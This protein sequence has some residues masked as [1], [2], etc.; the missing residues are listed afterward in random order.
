[1]MGGCISH[2]TPNLFSEFYHHHPR[3]VTISQPF[4]EVKPVRINLKA[5]HNNDKLEEQLSQTA[6]T[7]QTE[8]RNDHCFCVLC[9][10][11]ELTYLATGS[12]SRGVCKDSTHVCVPLGL[13]VGREAGTVLL[14]GGYVLSLP[15]PHTRYEFLATQLAPGSSLFTHSPLALQWCV[16][17]AQQKNKYS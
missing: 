8:H 3:A 9:E 6:K 10:Q 14:A 16:P 13:S 15:P 5:E 7:T 4:W 11:L 12:P 17:N 1:M 2:S